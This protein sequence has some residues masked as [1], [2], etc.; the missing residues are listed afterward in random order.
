MNLGKNAKISPKSC[1][2]KVEV[3]HS[4]LHDHICTLAKTQI[5]LYAT[6]FS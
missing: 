5:V 6:T 3:Y 4:N 2:I 1:K